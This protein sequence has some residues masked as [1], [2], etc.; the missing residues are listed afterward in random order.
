VTS[1][2]V[3]PNA[4]LGRSGEELSPDL[5]GRLQRAGVTEVQLF[6]AHAHGG[7]ALRATLAKDPT[8]GTLDAV[9]AIHNLLRPGTAPAPEAWTEDEFLESRGQ[10]VHIADFLRLWAENEETANDSVARE[11]QR[12]TEDRMLRFAQERGIR[13]VWESFREEKAAG[14]SARVLVYELSRVMNVYTAVWRLLF[15]PRAALVVAGDMAGEGLQGRTD[16][17]EYSEESLNKRYDLGRVG[18]YKINQRLQPAFEA[19]GFTAPPAGMTALTAQDV[20]AILHHLVEL[21]EGRGYTDDIDHLGNRRVRSVGELIANQFSVGLSRMARLV[22][23]RMSIVSDPDKIN[24]D[25]LVNAR[26][27]SAVIQQFFGSSQL[28]QFMDQ[29]N[30]LAELTHK[31]RLSA[32]GPGGLTRERAGFEVRDVHYSHYGRMCPIETPEGPNIG[33][34]NSLT[35]YSR[36]NDLGFIETPYRKVVRAVLRYPSTVTLQESM[37]LVLG[38]RTKVFAK[39]GETI[40]A[41]R[42]RELF[43]QMIVGAELAEDVRDWSVLSP[44]MLSAEIPQAEWDVEAEAI[45]LLAR[46]GDRI[47]DDLATRLAEQPVN[48]V[49]VVSRRAGAEARGVAPETI[50]NPVSLPVQV[51]QPTTSAYLAVPGTVLTEE[52]VERLY[53]AQMEGLVPGEPPLDAPERVGIDYTNGVPGLVS[54]SDVGRIALRQQEGQLSFVTPVV[55]RITAWLSANEEELARIAQANAPLTGEAPSSTSSSSAVSVVTSRSCARTRS[56]TWTSRPTSSSRSP[57]R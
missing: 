35:T 22:R 18:R 15:Q 29:T 12:S 31:R 30:P 50:R 54:P 37:R 4:L 33:L 55:T 23:E 43:R 16:Y 34:I 26:T 13:Y 11:M 47:T 45:P 6:D 41:T 17:G 20:L 24:I 5:I 8:R 21:H 7:T 28:S 51:F 52:V 27:V 46:R 10:T 38:E 25:D 44:R 9:F 3:A 48:L 2:P 56:T 42:G 49:R 36:I 53:E 32:L 14:K 19:L 40:D 39:A 1:F 57:R